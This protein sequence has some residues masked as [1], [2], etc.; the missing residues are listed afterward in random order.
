MEKA[1][2]RIPRITLLLDEDP[3]S[4]HRRSCLLSV[5]TSICQVPCQPLALFPSLPLLE[6]IW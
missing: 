4:S 5:T 1:L 6:L 2:L 3:G